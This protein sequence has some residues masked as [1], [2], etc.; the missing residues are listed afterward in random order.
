MSNTTI[1]KKFHLKKKPI[2]RWIIL[3]IPGALIALFIAILLFAEGLI[4]RE[5]LQPVKRIRNPEEQKTAFGNLLYGGLTIDHIKIPSSIDEI[6]LDAWF[7]KNEDSS[8]C[9]V[10][11]HGRCDTKMQLV[12]EAEQFYNAGYNVLLFDLRNHGLS[13]GEYTTYGWYEKQDTID[14]VRYVKEKYGIENFSLFGYS[15]GGAVVLQAFSSLPE[16]R[17]VVAVA[18]FATMEDVMLC[19]GKRLSLGIVPKYMMINAMERAGRIADFPPYKVSPLESVRI[20]EHQ[21]PILFVHSDG[22]ERISWKQCKRMKDAYPGESELW[23]VNKM[24]HL[25]YWQEMGEEIVNRAINLFG[26]TF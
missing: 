14:A 4:A 16:V 21:P 24:R 22:D 17:A 15:L 11:V 1:D 6:K 9:V 13:G 26:K 18:P 5:I 25:D 7:M 12:R 8:Y 19:Y 23:I 20:A 3:A 10:V 2:R